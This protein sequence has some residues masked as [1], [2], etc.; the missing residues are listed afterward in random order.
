MHTRSRITLTIAVLGM[1]SVLFSA[2]NTSVETEI[3]TQDLSVAN[4]QV[5]Q[6]VVVGLTQKPPPPTEPPPPTATPTAQPS[7]TPIPEETPIPNALFVDDFT[8]NTGWITEKN[9]RYGYE[10]IEGGYF[11]Y[12]NVPS[13]QVHSARSL[14]VPDI[15]LLTD[16]A[17]V[18]GPE[19]GYYGVICRFTNANNYYALVISSDGTYG[20]AK[21]EA[22]SF[23]FI[24]EGVDEA[25]VIQSGQAFNR[26]RGDCIDQTL[27]LYANGQKLLE[28]QDAT[29]DQGLIGL[30]AGTRD[31]PGLRVLYD[32]FVILER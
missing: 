27:T 6:T 1:V 17:Y 32:A 19:N 3:P 21:M 9:D 18:A 22:G 25:N 10:F 8:T 2:C 5:A 7:P 28:L 4:T 23:S 15:R 11:I 16:A 20:I 30:I 13:A 31:A 24:Q 12:V 14:E 26:V 29:F